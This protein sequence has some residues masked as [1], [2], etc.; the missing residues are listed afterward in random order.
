MFHIDGI[1]KTLTLSIQ[2]FYTLVYSVHDFYCMSVH[3][4][5]LLLLLL[6]LRFLLF[7]LFWWESY[8]VGFELTRKNM[9]P[10]RC[11]NIDSAATI[12]K[13]QSPKVPHAIAHNITC[14]TCR[15]LAQSCTRINVSSKCNM[16]VHSALV[17]LCQS[18]TKKC[19]PS[20]GITDEKSGDHEND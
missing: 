20:G 2:Y 8:K 11:R 7:Y 6:F 5:K 17:K 12:Y 10:V 3:P 19:Q 15:C 14:K 1:W 4:G 9:L 16:A 13:S 18:D